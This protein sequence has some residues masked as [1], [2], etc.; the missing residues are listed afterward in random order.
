MEDRRTLEPRTAILDED[1]EDSERAKLTMDI[2][3]LELFPDRPRCFLR[4]VCEEKTVIRGSVG[5]VRV[6]GCMSMR[7]S[8]DARARAGLTR[9][10]AAS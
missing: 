3:V 8:G 2:A 4:T 6:R 9:S 1:L 10:R 5:S 7:S